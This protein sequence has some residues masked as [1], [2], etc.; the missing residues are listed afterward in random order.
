MAGK[1]L[2][3]IESIMDGMTLIL[4]TKFKSKIS[5]Q[6]KSHI[7]TAACTHSRIQDVRWTEEV[8]LL[9]NPIQRSQVIRPGNTGE[10]HCGGV[11][12]MK[13]SKQLHKGTIRSYDAQTDKYSVLF[14]NGRTMEWELEQVCKM[15]VEEKNRQQWSQVDQEALG[16]LVLRVHGH[17][18]SSTS[19]TLCT[20]FPT[21]LSSSVWTDTQTWYTCSVRR[22]LTTT[23]HP[24]NAVYNGQGA[25]RQDRRDNA[26]SRKQSS[27]CQETHGPNG[28]RRRHPTDSDGLYRLSDSARM[29]MALQSSWFGVCIETSSTVTA[30]ST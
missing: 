20:P 3:R 23:R 7:E 26:Y 16:C 4:P 15:W 29:P 30:T 11:I 25:R 14:Q 2:H 13:K 24:K 18:V 10:D 1:G 27:G 21:L 5:A 9:V 22:S 8:S 19:H 28:R 17:A 12:Y 6:A